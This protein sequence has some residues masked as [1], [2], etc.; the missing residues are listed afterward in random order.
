MEKVH[1]ETLIFGF[2]NVSL[3]IYSNLNDWQKRVKTSLNFLLLNF[4]FRNFQLSDLKIKNNHF[5]ILKY[6]FQYLVFFFNENF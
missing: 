4:E 1:F 3:V 5:C 2:K 6:V